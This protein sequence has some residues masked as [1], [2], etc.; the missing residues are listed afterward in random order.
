MSDNKL[1]EIRDSVTYSILFVGTA[2]EVDEWIENPDHNET[3]E[4]VEVKF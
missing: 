4:I 2:D 3:Y 1:Y